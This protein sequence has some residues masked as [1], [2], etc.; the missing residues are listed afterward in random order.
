[1]SFSTFLLDVSANVVAL[2]VCSSLFKVFVLNY[3]TVN[4]NTGHSQAI[5]GETKRG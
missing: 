3:W 1:M 4:E 5:P 2:F